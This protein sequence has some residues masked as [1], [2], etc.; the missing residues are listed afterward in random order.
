MYYV[1]EHLRPDTNE[2][3]YV[4]KGK[5]YRANSTK[6]RNAYWK[7]IVNKA[8]GFTVNFVAKN[9]NYEELA[10][11]IEEERIDQLKR[12]GVILANFTLGGEGASGGENHHMWGKVHPD[13]G[14]KRPWVGKKGKD[15]PMYGKV[16][17]MKGIQ[18]PKGKD[19]PLYGRKR[20][21]G[22]GKPPKAVIATDINGNQ[23]N[24]K[25]ISEVEKFI[26]A[27]RG[28]IRKWCNM[29]KFV[30]NYTWEFA[31]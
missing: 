2:V 5:D 28:S 6:N 15:N 1:Y 27:Y 11:F 8:G 29:N 19:S 30:K 18:K 25:S 12:R 10:Y 4:G 7:N 17:A 14:S 3:F 16:G 13:K 20:P 23:L 9:I 26:G 21:E 24:F 22:G 31:K